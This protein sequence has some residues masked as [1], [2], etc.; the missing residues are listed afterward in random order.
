MLWAWPPRELRFLDGWLLRAADGHTRR[1]N[2]TRTSSW[3]GRDPARAIAAVESWYAARDLPVCFQLTAATAPAG[4]DG[5]LAATGYVRL[6]S[7]SILVIDPDRDISPTGV[8]LLHRAS[9]AVM[10]AICDPHWDRPT[11]ALRAALFARLRR[12]HRFALAL[13][14]GEPAAAGLVV[15]DGDLAGVFAMRTQAP[16]RGR[17][18]GLGIFKALTGW[19]ASHGATAV[20][21]Q[22]EDDNAPACRLY[23]KFRPRRIY[24]YW[25]RER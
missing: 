15:L 4:L 6:P 12:P 20:Y 5:L 3:S 10:N 22:V 7:V 16:F 25:Y 19:A 13:V 11:R 21:L 17:G 24:G 18:L 9:P 2:S 14:G 23:D 1:I 8:E